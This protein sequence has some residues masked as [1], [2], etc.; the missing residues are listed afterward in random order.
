MS[1]DHATAVR[2][3]YDAAAATDFRRLRR[4]LQESESLPEAA[5]ELGEFGRI[6]L[7]LLD[8][9]VELDFSSMPGFPE[10]NRFEGHQGWFEFFRAWL[11]PWE[12][13]SWTLGRCEATGDHVLIEAEQWGRIPGGLEYSTPFYGVWTFERHRVIR[14]QFFPTLDEAVAA[15]APGQ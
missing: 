6:N 7:E 12:D 4:A 15:S 10:G 8:P 2:G 14:V 11:A 13:F 9:E 5:T 1:G 3:F